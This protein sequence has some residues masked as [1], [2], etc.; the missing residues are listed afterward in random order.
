MGMPIRGTIN[1]ISLNIIKSIKPGKYC[2]HMNCQQ[3]CK[4]SRKRIS[5]SN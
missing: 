5:W 2:V 4:I 1:A 3:M